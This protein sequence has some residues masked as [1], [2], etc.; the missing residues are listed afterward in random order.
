MLI[1][2]NVTMEEWGFLYLG[3]YLIQNRDEQYCPINA[4][5][6][7]ESAHLRGAVGTLGAVRVTDERAHHYLLYTGPP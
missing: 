5:V 3:Q 1:A 2:R 4:A 6:V 7:T